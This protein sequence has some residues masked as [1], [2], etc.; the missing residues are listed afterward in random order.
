MVYYENYI[1]TWF[2]NL[3]EKKYIAFYNTEKIREHKHH[4]FF[5]FKNLKLF[6]SIILEKV[7]VTESCLTLWPHGI[8]SMEFFRPKYW[9]G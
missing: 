8:Q 6:G 2:I 1:N 5:V 9:S 3:I 7:K 4:L